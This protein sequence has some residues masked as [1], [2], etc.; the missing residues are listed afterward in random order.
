MRSASVTAVLASTA[1]TVCLSA[2]TAAAAQTVE[3]ELHGFEEVP[4]ISTSGTGEFHGEIGENSLEFELT[5]SD[6]ESTVQQAHI[7]F[8]Q[9]RV[10]GGISVFLCTNLPNAPTADI[11]ACPQNFPATVT[12]VIGPEDV[13]GPE[14]Q[15]I[16]PGAFEELVEAIES[17]VT[18]VNVH[19][20]RFPAGE[21]RGQLNGDIAAF[22]RLL[23]EFVERRGEQRD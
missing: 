7:H 8:G 10:N 12:G 3:A 23:E 2:P 17:G 20:E 14:E 18:Y 9:P 19:T 13:I 22:V 11:P 5:Y 16:E 6:L 15:G 21:I 4:P 1:L